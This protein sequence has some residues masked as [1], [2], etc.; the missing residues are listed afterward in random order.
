MNQGEGQREQ[1][2]METVEN[3]R[4]VLLWKWK[5]QMDSKVSPSFLA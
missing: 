2:V 5:K 1:E 3:C 4:I